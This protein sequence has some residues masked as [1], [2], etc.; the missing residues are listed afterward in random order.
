MSLS[1]GK[2]DSDLSCKNVAEEKSITLLRRLSWHGKAPLLAN[3]QMILHA[4]SKSGRK[5]KQLQA[6]CFPLHTSMSSCAG[7]SQGG[8]EAGEL[9]LLTPRKDIAI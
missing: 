4:R 9:R 6:F 7:K 2:I 1:L 5:L 8:S 3:V